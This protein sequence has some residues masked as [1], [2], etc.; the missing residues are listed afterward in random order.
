MGETVNLIVI[1]NPLDT[2][3]RA[4][5]KLVWFHKKPLSEYLDGLP[6]EVTWAV[7]VNAQPIEQHLW[8]ETYLAPDDYLTI[9]PIPEGGGGGGKGVMRIAAM[10]VVAIAA[11]YT[12]GA[13]AAAYT[14]YADAA[15]AAANGAGAAFTAVSVG[16]GAVVTPASSFTIALLPKGFPE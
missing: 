2:S 9:M 10:I 5:E 8:S 14:G 4:L 1:Y 7:C 6:D 11:V 12:G 15:A 3:D 16:V 13:A